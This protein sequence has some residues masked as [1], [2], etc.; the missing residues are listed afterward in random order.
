MLNYYFAGVEGNY[1]V[2][3]RI[4]E[5]GYRVGAVLTTY[6]EARSSVKLL[7]SL[8]RFREK[9]GV[10]VIVDSGAYTFIAMDKD[11]KNGKKI[12]NNEYFEMYKNKDFDS[13]VDGYIEWMKKNSASFDYAVELDLQ[14]IVGNDKVWEWRE[15]YKQEGLISKMIFV[16]HY[17]Q[18]TMNTVEKWKEMGITYVGIG[19]EL[20]GFS[21][22]VE[23]NSSFAVG[24][25][26]NIKSKGL[27]IH[28]F[29]FTGNR[30]FETRAVDS[31]DSTTWLSAGRFANVFIFNGRDGWDSYNLR[32][33]KNI[34]EKILKDKFMNDV[35][36]IEE[37]KKEYNE[38]K[39]YS[40][41]FYNLYQIQKGVD[42]L[43]GVKSEDGVG[44][45]LA[46]EPKIVAEKRRKSLERG[47]DFEEALLIFNTNFLCGNC[48]VKS[49]CPVRGNDED[50][51]YFVKLY[52]R[53][54]KIESKDDIVNIVEN[55]FK[56]D[57]KNW[58]KLL[59]ESRLSGQEGDVKMMKLQDSMLKT[60]E[61]L[62]RMKYGLAENQINV[63]NL[64][65]L[66]VSS[67]SLE[68]ELE[69]V[70]RE[71]G[72]EI[73]RKVKEKIERVEGEQESG[74]EE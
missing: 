5:K 27:K 59:V 49:S 34:V 41:N 66:S 42:Y 37:V 11:Y 14:A 52:D 33:D 58:F 30:I 21:K 19:G 74:G 32:K 29:G 71:Y 2:V 47:R 13:Y 61:L 60:L 18:D 63:L 25:R 38:G 54:V 69:E 62:Y 43:N 3:E 72:D 24:L 7:E 12:K 56:E 17:P 73:A 16:Y 20:G 9:Y 65:N 4:L 55:I 44:I 39:F 50:V 57:Y 26:Q 23:M 53:M 8:K 68:E 35:F 10:K 6:L 40:F 45:V 51:C 31:V 15:K 67:K 36:D 64:G 46:E 70:R 1:D 48:P 22:T 28:I